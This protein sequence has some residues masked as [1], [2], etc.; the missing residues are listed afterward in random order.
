MI[1]C[2][3]T[4]REVKRWRGRRFVVVSRVFCFVIQSSPIDEIIL[5]Y[6]VRTV[7]ILGRYEDTLPT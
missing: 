5:P 7:E 3:Y 4:T 1:D 6:L 2:S